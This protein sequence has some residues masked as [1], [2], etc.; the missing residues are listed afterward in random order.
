MYFPLYIAK[1]IVKSSTTG[2]SGALVKLAI[3]SIALSIAV[4]LIS[5][6]VILGF[7]NEISGKIY[8][9]WGNIHITDVKSTRNFELRPIHNI[10][11]IQDSILSISGLSFNIAPRGSAPR[12]K[13]TKGGVAYVTPFITFP[14]IISTQKEI[15]AVVLKGVHTSY[16]RDFFDSYLK[17]GHFEIGADST[18]SRN[19]MISAQTAARLNLKLNDPID[20]HFLKDNNQIKRRLKVGAIYKSGLEEYDRKFSFIDMRLIQ[21]VIGWERDMVGGLEVYV[22]DIDDAEPIA[23]YI[24]QEILPTNL[25]AQTIQ[26]K[27][28]SIFEWLE[29]QNIN[30]TMILLLMIIVAIIN[31]STGLLILIL[32]RSSMVGVL[33][34]LGQSNWGVRKVFIISGIYIMCLALLLGNIIGLGFGWLQSKFGF[35]KLDEANYYLTEVPIEFNLWAIIAINIG[36][37]IITAFVMVIPSYLVTKITPMSILRFD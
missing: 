30:E 32:E 23:D 20:V 2:Y 29:L 34:S 11:P 10:G 12:M 33:K 4:M 25:Y 16:K 17:E 22:E 21:D 5:T 37:I 36:A 13:E 24:Y 18:V 26:E 27:Q 19:L 31:M 9:F 3:A 35:L 8:G 6:A 15:E 14:T 28:S 7:K 1:R